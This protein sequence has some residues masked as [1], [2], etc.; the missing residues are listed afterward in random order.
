M[1]RA[2]CETP[3][4]RQ[5]TLPRAPTPKCQSCHNS[6]LLHPCQHWPVTAAIL[7][8][9]VDQNIQLP[10][11]SFPSLPFQ[12]FQVLFNSLFKV[13]CIFPSRYLFAIGVPLIFSLWWSIPPVR[14]AIPSNSTLPQPG[15]NQQ[16]QSTDRSF[17]LIAALF[18][19]TWLR[20]L[21]KPGCIDHNSMPQATPI[22]NLGSS[23][24][25]RPYWGNPC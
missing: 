4:H 25:S 9:Q 16:P 12:Q 15:T 2:V 18:Q 8:H 10:S 7:V 22:L 20:E 1:S 21:A 17:T 5:G 14:T 24:F 11:H 6:K 3:W 23:R 13:L 19:E